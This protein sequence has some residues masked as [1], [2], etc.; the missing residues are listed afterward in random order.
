MSIYRGISVAALLIILALPLGGGVLISLLPQEEHAFRTVDIE[1]IPVAITTGGPKYEGELFIYEEMLTIPQER[2]KKRARLSDPTV[3]TMDEDGFIY[4]VDSG[5][6]RVAVFDPEGKFVRDFGK[7]GEESGEFMTPILQSVEGGIVTIYDMQI[8]RVTR[9][10]TDGALIDTT[11]VPMFRFPFTP[12]PKNPTVS[13]IYRAQDEAEE[14]ERTHIMQP[15][16]LF[17]RPGGGWIVPEVSF[18]YRGDARSRA[19]LYNADLDTVA[20]V[21]SDQVRSGTTVVIRLGGR[22]GGSGRMP[23]RMSS[24][25]GSVMAREPHRL[26][27]APLPAV[28]YVPGRGIVVTTGEGPV[29]E[30]YNLDGDLIGRVRIETPPAPVTPEDERLFDQGFRKALIATEEQSRETRRTER[31]LNRRPRNRRE[32]MEMMEMVSTR[33]RLESM[34]RYMTLPR[35]RAFWDHLFVDDAGYTWLRVPGT[36]SWEPEAIRHR[37]WIVSPEGEFLGSTLAPPT[38]S[39]RN[40]QEQFRAV[41][42]EHGHFMSVTMDESTGTWR[43]TVYRLTSAVPEFSYP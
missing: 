18:R 6:H 38:M 35:T 34:K 22:G 43:L 20:V 25:T 4:V 37:Y 17:E 32:M 26:P 42:L 27:Y 8:D 23:S 1:G 30:W 40:F 14:F 24:S 39:S 3:F 16:G 13:D 7:E 11:S 36:Y 9:F 5:K 29:L 28:R 2:V 21:N 10:T 31:D 15:V 19:V 33:G 12:I 41:P